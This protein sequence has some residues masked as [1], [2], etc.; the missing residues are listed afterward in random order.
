M[1]GQSQLTAS[2][3]PFRALSEGT[4]EAAI[5]TTSPVRGLRPCRA[6]LPVL[7][8]EGPEPRDA[9]RLAPRKG[10]REGFEHGLDGNLGVRLQERN[11]RRDAPGD[12]GLI[13]LRVLVSQVSHRTNR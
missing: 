5:W 3:S 10:V 1:Q 6:G 12:V 4:V 2:Q 7:H 13:H 11:L 8:R 9:H